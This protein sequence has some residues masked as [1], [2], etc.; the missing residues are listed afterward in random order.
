MF[1]LSVK[2]VKNDVSQALENAFGIVGIVL[3]GSRA[4]D[5]HRLDSDIDIGIYY[6]ETRG[7]DTKIVNKI[8]AQLDDDH[9]ENLVSSLGGWGDWINGGGWLVVQ[10]FHVD[11]IFYLKRLFL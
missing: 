3:G 1:V 6:D 11:L 5:R 7:F 4:R 2:Q 9:R 8:A 10:G